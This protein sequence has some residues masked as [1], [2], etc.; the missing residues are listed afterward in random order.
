MVIDP[1]DVEMGKVWNLWWNVTLADDP[2]AWDGEIR[3]LNEMQ[4]GLGG[5]TADQRLIRDQMGE[6]CRAH[7]LFP[8]SIEIRCQEIGTGSLN[9]P[10]S[11]GCEGRGL[12]D[13][14]GYHDPQSLSDQRRELLTGYAHALKKWLER[15][16][17]ESPLES[18]VFGFLGQPTR[19]KERFA[20]RL[21]AAVDGGDASISSLKNLSRNECRLTQGES[22]LGTGARPFNCFDCEGCP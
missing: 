10:L 18:K 22:I 8:R 9:Q 20:E 4:G 13:S 3:L 17:A 11:L 15:G 21:A 14:L 6:F 2:E 19:A 1:P 16:Q 7:P 5:L 12:L